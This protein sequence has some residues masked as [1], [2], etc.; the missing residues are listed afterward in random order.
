M[1]S[2]T[3]TGGWRAVTRP[4]QELPAYDD[5]IGTE[6]GLLLTDGTGGGRRLSAT[7]RFTAMAAAPGELSPS[8]LRPGPGGV[9]LALTDDRRHVLRTGPGGTTWTVLPLPP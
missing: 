8:I 5:V 2:T 9:V 4:G 7:G 3:G 6:D 1:W